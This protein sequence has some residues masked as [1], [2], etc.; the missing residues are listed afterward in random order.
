M[1][2]IKTKEYCQLRRLAYHDA[3]TGVY[4]RNWFNENKYNIEKRYVYFIDINDLFKVNKEHGHDAGDKH[5]I[6][7]SE[8]MRKYDDDILVRYAGDEF[9]LFSDYKDSVTNNDIFSVGRSLI[10]N[11]IDMAIYRA[12]KNMLKSKRIFKTTI[13]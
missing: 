9:M 6:N 4:N 13:F 8:M 11:D 10:K 7:A 12:D 2:L 1:K 3:L 5:I